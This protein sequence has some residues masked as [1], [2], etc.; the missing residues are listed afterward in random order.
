MLPVAPIAARALAGPHEVYTRLEVWRGGVQLLSDLPIL[1][2]SVRASLQSRVTRSLDLSVDPA[3]FPEALTDPLAPFGSEIRAWR[4]VSIGGATHHPSLVWPVFRGPITSVAM[5]TLGPCS[6]AAVDRAGDVSDAQFEFPFGVPAGARLH[7]TVKSVITEAVADAEFDAF[8]LA[9]RALPSLT[10]D[11]DRGKALDDMASGAGGFWYALADGTFTLRPVPWVYSGGLP[12]LTIDPGNPIFR[13]AS[14]RYSREGV[15]NT[16]V[17]RSERTDG[18][19][20]ER[21]VARITDPASPLVYAGPFGRRVMH[22]DAQSAY[23][24]GG[25]QIVGDTLL[26]RSQ[27]VAQSWSATITA[28]PPLE[29]G[30]LIQFDIADRSGRRRRS[31]QVVSGFSMPLTADG[32][33]SL[34]LRA[35][36][37]KGEAVL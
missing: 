34:Q 18:S 3:Y 5:D 33:M 37:P 24:G 25:L 23:G 35:L 11:E 19:A 12:D 28:Y 15:V 16:V 32:D 27:A 13:S 31:K 17:V 1:G 7:S 6:V 2:G 8:T 20:P 9:D 4:G 36:T 10:W 21:Y 30:D 14:L 26:Q 29:L 22:A